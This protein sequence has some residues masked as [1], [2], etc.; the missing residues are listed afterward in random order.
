M[1]ASRV[2]LSLSVRAG[3]SRH[4]STLITESREFDKARTIALYRALDGEV[5]PRDIAE[6]SAVAGKRVCYP[7]VTPNQPLAFLTAHRWIKGAFGYEPEGEHISIDQ[8]DLML[9]PGVAFSSS[10]DRLGFGGGHYDRT[11]SVYSGVS[12]GLS[13]P[14]QICETMITDS[15]DIRVD[16]VSVAHGYPMS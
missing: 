11:L 10:G 8:I 4:I 13:Y 16:R 2:E 3:Y 12:I 6:A 14:F 9:V 5:D 1:R 15:W 7:R